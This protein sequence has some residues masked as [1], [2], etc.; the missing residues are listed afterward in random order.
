MVYHISNI[1]NLSCSKLQQCF[2]FPSGDPASQCQCHAKNARVKIAKFVPVSNRVNFGQKS[3]SS[4]EKMP[5]SICKIV[6]VQNKKSPCQ[7]SEFRSKF[8]PPTV[9]TTPN[10]GFIEAKHLLRH[11][12]YT[13]SIPEPSHSSFYVIV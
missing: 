7:I 11:T 10:F 4:G 12:V 8:S 13:F 1:T 9:S 2:F 6:P 3:A 5:V